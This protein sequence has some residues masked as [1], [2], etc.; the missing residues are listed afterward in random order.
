MGESIINCDLFCYFFDYSL[1]KFFIPFQIMESIINCDLFCA[2]PKKCQCT[3][4]ENGFKL[5]V[6]LLALMSNN[7]AGKDKYLLPPGDMVWKDMFAELLLTA[8]LWH[9]SFWSWYLTTPCCRPVVHQF[10][11]RGPLSLHFRSWLTDGCYCYFSRKLASLR[12]PDIEIISRSDNASLAHHAQWN[13]VSYN[14]AWD[15]GLYVDCHHYRSLT[16]H[17]TKK[18]WAQLFKGWL[19]HP[20]DKSLSSKC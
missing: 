3:V 14:L 12:W 13:I 5:L 2:A 7:V 18:T 20:S 9:C 16:L 6:E 4:N 17:G 1:I 11:K 15:D 10:F 19:I 8:E